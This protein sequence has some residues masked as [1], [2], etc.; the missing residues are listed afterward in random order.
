LKSKR[1]QQAIVLKGIKAF[2]NLAHTDDFNRNTLKRGAIEI[3][4]DIQKL[5]INDSLLEASCKSAI[6]YISNREKKA[7]LT[8]FLLD[9]I[10]FDG[11][12]QSQSGE[13]LTQYKKMLVS[14]RVMTKHSYN[15][16]PHSKLIFV[17][18]NLKRIC[19]RDQKKQ[20]DK[21]KFIEISEI[22]SI[23]KGRCSPQLQRRNAFGNFYA[24][25]DRCFACFSAEKNLSLE[26]E[27]KNERDDWVNALSMVKKSSMK[28][29]NVYK[30]IKIFKYEYM[31]I[32]F[33]NQKNVES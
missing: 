12:R 9:E 25:E 16:S 3:I 18:G 10:R 11:E 26:C 5:W 20:N 6:N 33:G 24:D 8:F 19:W 7:G 23:Q 28:D 1:N 31:A 27:S 15:A 14:G 22:H 17:S 21:L 30:K 13:V 2:Q 4:Q 32:S 29:R